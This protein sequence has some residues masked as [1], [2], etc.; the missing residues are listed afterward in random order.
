MA[1][2]VTNQQGEAYIRHDSGWSWCVGVE[3]V[4]L[5][6]LESWR[7]VDRSGKVAEGG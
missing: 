1:P 2:L 5:V 6:E 4:E 7:G 3:F